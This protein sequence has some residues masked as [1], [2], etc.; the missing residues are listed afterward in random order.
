MGLG[1]CDGPTRRAHRD[2]AVGDD[3][4]ATVAELFWGDRFATSAIGGRHLECRTLYRD[5][6]DLADGH[7]H[8]SGFP[9]DVC[10]SIAMYGG[11]EGAAHQLRQC[12]GAAHLL[13]GVWTGM[14]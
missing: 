11:E 7:L 3:G 10:L 14:Q 13:V 2:R 9:R 5:A 8:A 1:A 4:G 12:P 6:G